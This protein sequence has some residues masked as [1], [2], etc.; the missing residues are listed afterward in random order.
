MGDTTHQAGPTYRTLAHQ[1][2]RIIGIFKR[3]ERAASC[4]L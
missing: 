1:F 2:E 4:A 3:A